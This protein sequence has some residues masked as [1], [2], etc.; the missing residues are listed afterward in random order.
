MSRI[1]IIGGGPGGYEA[2]LVAVSLGAEVILIDRDGIGGA[3]VLFDCVPS[4]SLIATSDRVTGIRD[5]TRLGLGVE[6]DI[7][8][9]LVTV[10]ARIKALAAQQS[11][12]IA[13]RLVH[14]GVQLIA[15]RGRF[16]ATQD[17]PTF[18]IFAMTACSTSSATGATSSPSRGI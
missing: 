4:K 8:V 11:L 16:A 7:H 9:D 5:A 1:V 14:D 17:S 10:N 6:G 15:G 13:H 18:R 3:C 2:A 12:D